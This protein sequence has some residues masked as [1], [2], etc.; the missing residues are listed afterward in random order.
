MH[1]DSFLVQIH[2]QM[3]YD[4]LFHVQIAIIYFI[5]YYLFL[6]I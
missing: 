6:G 4:F 1:Y 3:R 2:S 5:H